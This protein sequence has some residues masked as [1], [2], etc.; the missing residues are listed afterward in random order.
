MIPLA[1]PNVGERERSLLT[2]CIDEG[3]IS[4]VGPYV[5]R[6]EEALRDSCGAQ[7]AVAVTSGTAAIHLALRMAGLQPDE[8]VV[9]PSLTFIA[10]ANAVRQ[11]L[12]WP[13]FVDVDPDTWQID[14]AAV[15]R[16]LTT[17]CE[18]REG[19]LVNI[20]TG[21]PVVGIVPVHLLGHPV[22]LDEL[23]AIAV[24]F[25]L[26]LVEDAAEAMGTWFGDGTPVGGRG[27]FV[28][29]S[30]NGNKIVSTGGGGAI[31]TDDPQIAERARFLST[32]AK[33]EP[34][35]YIHSEIGYNYRLT[36]LQAAVGI[37]QMERLEDFVARKVEIAAT[38]RSA[39]ERAGAPFEY[40]RPTAGVRCTWWLSTV[41]LPD[42]SNLRSIMH[43]MREKGVMVR[44]L[45]QPLHRS[46]AMAGSFA[47]D[48]STADRLY[49]RAL[50]LPSSTG[51]TDEEVQTVVTAL[52]SSMSG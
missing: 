17:Q 33:S 51:L 42:G 7:A 44:P 18:R 26:F 50:S 8:E 52:L 41:V 22:P 32:Q 45:W 6:F 15:R 11:H 38:Y 35:E 27:R 40:M 25:D 10:P 39:F 24:E 48:C 4:S 46:P 31:L 28:C 13:V 16:F 9:V 19:R 14:P 29:F 23:A 36:S 47:A 2:D 21:R 30:F 49:A 20:S 3:W 1:I 5:T 34:D 12:A 37:A 43:G